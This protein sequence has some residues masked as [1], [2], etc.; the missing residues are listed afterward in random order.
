MQ[1]FIRL[2][3]S[4]INL[5]ITILASI[6]PVSDRLKLFRVSYGCECH[7][8]DGGS[9]AMLQKGAKIGCKKLL[10]K[11]IINHLVDYLH[12]ILVFSFASN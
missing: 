9:W 4:I 10:K 6:V 1:K 2:L 11:T 5:P 7:I 8:Y 3:H 12:F